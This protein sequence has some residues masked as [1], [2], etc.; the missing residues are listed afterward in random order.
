MYVL[1][2][3]KYVLSIMSNLLKV[4]ITGGIGTGKTT[5]ANLFKI[6]GIA[7]Y[8]ADRQA[9]ILMESDDELIES[10]IKLF[11]KEAYSYARLNRQFLAEIVF[12]DEEKLIKLNAL[13]HPAV[14]IDF[15]LWTSSFNEG[16]VIKEA[17]LLIETGSYK[18]LDYLILV[19]SPLELRI[20][21][22]K[23]RDPQRTTKLIERII[24]KQMNSEEAA[25][26]A[27]FVI[28]N[29]EKQLLIPQ[30]QELHS[31]LNKKADPDI[32][33]PTLS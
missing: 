15:E 10:I 12:K 5:V 18:E 3:H 8:D 28:H 21:R 6:F 23:K 31:L 33:E 27:N 7:I 2:S 20:E 11:G 24:D 22:I 19:D 26:L 1:T 25:K 9:K 30:V 14:A 32:S 4:G 29:D 17:A 13:V 16:Y